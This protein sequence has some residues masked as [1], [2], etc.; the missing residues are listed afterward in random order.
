MNWTTNKIAVFGTSLFLSTNVF[1]ATSINGIYQNPKTGGFV[2]VSQ[3]GNSYVAV[4][5]ASIPAQEISIA[6][7]NGQNF[8]PNMIGFW[9][10]TIGTANSDG[11]FTDSGYDSL[12]M[13]YANNSSTLVGNLLQS[14]LVQISSSPLAKSQG[15]DCAKLIPVGTNSTLYK[16]W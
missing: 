2:V 16:I 3:N 1:A 9:G 15:I 4:S 8:Q 5:L 12:G 14:T 6:L 11:T 13:C 7:V 10:Y